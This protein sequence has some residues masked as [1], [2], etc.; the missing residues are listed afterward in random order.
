MFEITNSNDL[1]KDPKV[2]VHFKQ[3]V[4]K[5]VQDEHF[6]LDF[7]KVVIEVQIKDEKDIDGID[8]DKDLDDVKL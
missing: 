3:I 5:Q 1:N 8:V 7:V 4:A 6:A 2:V